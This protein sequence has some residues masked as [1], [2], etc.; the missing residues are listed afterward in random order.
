M[1]ALKPA[2]FAALLIL[3]ATTNAIAADDQ[4]AT[5][6]TAA[7]PAAAAAPATPAKPAKPSRDDQVIC[8]TETPTGSR[9]GGKTTCLKRREWDQIAADARDNQ[10]H[11]NPV[12]LPPAH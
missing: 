9:L 6:A 7:A 12:F 2:A 5:S 10:N 3:A 11:A 1:D 4:P 8:K